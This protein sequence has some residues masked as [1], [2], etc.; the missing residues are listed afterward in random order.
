MARPSLWSTAPAWALD[1]IEA[2]FRETDG[3]TRRPRKGIMS[4]GELP[5][6]FKCLHTSNDS[7][8]LVE[9]RALATAFSAMARY[10]AWRLGR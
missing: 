1:A 9:G 10:I 2:L 7:M 5:E 6:G 4:I 3:L 8:R